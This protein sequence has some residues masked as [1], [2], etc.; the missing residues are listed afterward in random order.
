TRRPAARLRPIDD[1]PV[2][3]GDVMTVRECYPSTDTAAIAAR[4]TLA[5]A[6][7]DGLLPAGVSQAFGVSGGAMAALW[8]AMSAGGLQV[9]HFRHERGAA[10]AA[11]ESHFACGRP[12]L[13]FT[14]TGPGL[15]N[16]LTG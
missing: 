7:V 16:A 15:T 5:A 14:T 9:C 6:L 3:A 10:F 4:P 12:A 13:V 11:T 8:H 2:A 1:P